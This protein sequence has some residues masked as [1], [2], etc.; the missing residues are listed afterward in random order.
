MRPAAAPKS[1]VLVGS[2]VVGVGLFG[3]FALANAYGHAQPIAL[4]L[5][6]HFLA[7]AGGATSPTT[8]LAWPATIGAIT[9]AAFMAPSSLRWIYRQARVRPPCRDAP[10]SPHTPRPYALPARVAVA[11]AA[12]A[13]ARK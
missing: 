9:L 6:A 2:F 3:L 4:R 8:L 12:A 7:R 5:A 10:A 11:L 1:L 13:R